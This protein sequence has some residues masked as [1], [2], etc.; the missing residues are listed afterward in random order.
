[1]TLQPNCHSLALFPSDVEQF[2]IS[3]TSWCV[4]RKPLNIFRNVL[5][6]G[7]CF[8][9]TACYIDLLLQYGTMWTF[10]RQVSH[11][12]PANLFTSLAWCAVSSALRKQSVCSLGSDLAG[13]VIVRGRFRQTSSFCQGRAFHVA[14]ACFSP[15]QTRYPHGGS[16][17]VTPAEPAM[18]HHLIP[19][20]K[21]FSPMA[22]LF[23]HLFRKC[24]KIL[25]LYL[26]CNLGLNFHT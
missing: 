19:C 26:L 14:T 22:L 18:I 13:G 7:L 20:W 8:F 24:P 9:F 11:R 16:H 12:Y 17:P 5:K 10:S 1:M 4:E 23:S 6:Y 3:G 21:S 2:S 25:V 15:E